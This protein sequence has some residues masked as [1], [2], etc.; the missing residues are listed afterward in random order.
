VGGGANMWGW[1]V[2]TARSEPFTLL[3]LVRK[4]HSGSEKNLRANFYVERAPAVYGRGD[5]VLEPSAY[6][7]LVHGGLACL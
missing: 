4:A 2:P 6:E 3:F 7:H 5:V 1:G